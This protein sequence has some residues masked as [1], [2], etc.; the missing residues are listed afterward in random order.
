MFFFIFILCLIKKWN[1]VEAEQ[2]EVTTASRSTNLYNNQ[3]RVTGNTKNVFL[4]YML[5]SRLENLFNLSKAKKLVEDKH[6]LN[7]DLTIKQSSK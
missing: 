6:F 7:N 1:S 3:I 2:I 4:G 5:L